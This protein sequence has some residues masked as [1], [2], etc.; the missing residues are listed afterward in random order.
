MICPYTFKTIKLLTQNTY[1]DDNLQEQT[2]LVET[3]D[4]AECQENNCA[5]WINGKCNYNQGINET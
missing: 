1:N 4:F 5:V 2:V 3:R